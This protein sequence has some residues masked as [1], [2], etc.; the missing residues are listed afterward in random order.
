MTITGYMFNMMMDGMCMPSCSAR[1]K[2]AS[3]D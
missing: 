3:T 1:Q 2:S